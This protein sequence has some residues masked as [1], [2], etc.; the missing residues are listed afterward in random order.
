MFFLALDEEKIGC[1]L[2]EDFEQLPDKYRKLLEDKCSDIRKTQDRLEFIFS[3]QEVGSY[4]EDKIRKYEK[5]KSR[6]D[7]RNLDLYLWSNGIYEQEDID[8]LFEVQQGRCYYTGEKLIKHPKNYS[9]DHIVPVTKDGSS[10]PANLALTLTNNNREKHNH[11][12]RKYFSVLEKRYGKDWRIK[13]RDFCKKVD[14]GRRAI[15]KN[16]KKYISSHLEQFESKLRKEFPNIEIDYSLVDGDVNLVV[17][18]VCIYFPAGFIR[19]KRKFNSFE[20]VQKITKAILNKN[21]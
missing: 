5:N 6:S 20:Y 18:Y 9:I 3:S 16:R 4:V 13:Q 14:V 15:D 1:I 10:W 17:N 2:K 11:S 12:K 8:Q 19:E 21:T 7:A